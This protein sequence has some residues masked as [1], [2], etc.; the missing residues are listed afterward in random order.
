MDTCTPVLITLFALSWK[1]YVVS[2]ADG[3]IYKIYAKEPVPPFKQY[4]NGLTHKKIFCKQGF[5]QI[6]KKRDPDEF[7]RKYNKLIQSGS[8]DQDQVGGKLT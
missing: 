8:W 6:M 1:V 4:Q 7:N 2:I 3:S 5:M